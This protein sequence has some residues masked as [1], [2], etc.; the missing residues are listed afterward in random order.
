MRIGLFGGSFDP[1]H[2]GHL[3]AA[4]EARAALGLDLV[5]FVVAARPPHK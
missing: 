5:L 2:L 1:I 4:A 3:L